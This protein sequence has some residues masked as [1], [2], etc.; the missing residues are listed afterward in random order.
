M[1]ELTQKATAKEYLTVQKEGVLCRRRDLEKL[2]RKNGW[3]FIR[4][5]RRHDIWGDGTNE[6]EIPRHNE[7]IEDT[8]KAIIRRWG[9]K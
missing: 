8:A 6:D 4:H 7:V 9:L 5:G 3:H 1:I 2:F